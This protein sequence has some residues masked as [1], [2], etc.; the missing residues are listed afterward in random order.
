MP[1]S[2]LDF[3]RSERGTA[4]RMNRPL[5]SVA[6]GVLVKPDGQV[7]IAQRPA[8]KLAAGKWEFPGGKIEVGETP[9]AALTRELHEEL[10]I[11]V[12]AAEP[13]LRFRHDYSDRCVVLDTW[14]VTRWDGALQ[15]REGQ[16]F[17]WREPS[18]LAA[19]DVLP[20]VAPIVRVLGLP[21]HYVFTPPAVTEAALRARIAHLPPGAL[22]RLR[23]PALDDVAYARLAE[24][25][26]ELGRS[27]GIRVLLDRDPALVTALD[28]DGWHADGRALARH[29]CRPLPAT[30]L[31]AASIHDATQREAAQRLGVDL[32]VLGPVAATATHPGA[33]GLGW[34]QFESI[35]EDVPFAVY[36]IGGVGPADLDTARR[37]GAQG[38]AGISAYWRD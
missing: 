21:A 15:S 2:C 7:L 31:V 28:A 4:A 6:C 1:G 3:R 10:G 37:H 14:R 19:L 16:A 20:T 13:L 12:R 9:L 30:R 35:R 36:A 17:A 23:Q 27:T 38:I 22:L 24:R 26:V 34:P 32:A 29:A 11:T 5:I 33:V 25:V 8:G 18:S